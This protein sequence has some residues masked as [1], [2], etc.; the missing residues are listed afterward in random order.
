VWISACR[1]SWAEEVRNQLPRCR[2]VAYLGLNIAPSACSTHVYGGSG[3]AAGRIHAAFIVYLL[4]APL[5]PVS[6]TAHAPHPVRGP[7]RHKG[8]HAARP[9]RGTPHSAAAAA[10][11][12][13]AATGHAGLETRADEPLDMS[14]EPHLAHDTRPLGLKVPARDR[15]RILVGQW[16]AS[17]RRAE[18]PGKDCAGARRGPARQRTAA[19]P[20]L[21]SPAHDA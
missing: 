16:L 15:L 20:P 17:K 18:A 14:T 3:A 2:K 5:G 10:P 12:G 7:P 11:S 1:A 9:G 19:W 6:G 8:A 4:V 13:P 21:P